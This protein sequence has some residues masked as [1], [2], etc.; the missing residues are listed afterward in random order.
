MGPWAVKIWTL[1]LGQLR[2]PFLLALEVGEVPR[3][4]ALLLGRAATHRPATCETRHQRSCAHVSVCSPGMVQPQR[5]IWHR[6]AHLAAA[7]VAP[8]SALCVHR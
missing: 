5:R 8:Q 7:S 1:A 2:D 4:S 6:G 3:H